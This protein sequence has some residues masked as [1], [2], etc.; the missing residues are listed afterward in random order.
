MQLITNKNDFLDVH[1][2]YVLI[3]MNIT[4]GDLNVHFKISDEL[5]KSLSDG[6]N[7]I[8]LDFNGSTF[9][10]ALAYDVMPITIDYLPYINAYPNDRIFSNISSSVKFK[11]KIKN[12]NV[13]NTYMRGINC[14]INFM[15]NEQLELITLENVSF[16]NFMNCQTQIDQYTT[17]YAPTYYKHFVLSNLPNKLVLNNCLIDMNGTMDY[18]Y[19]GGYR[20]KDPFYYFVLTCVSHKNVFVKINVLI[21]KLYSIY[22]SGKDIGIVISGLINTTISFKVTDFHYM[23]F[24]KY[25]YCKDDTPTVFYEPTTELDLTNNYKTFYTNMIKESSLYRRFIY[26]EILKLYT[27]E[28]YSLSVHNL[29]KDGNYYN[30]EISFELNN[31]T[32]NWL[33]NIT[34]N[35]INQL[36]LDLMIDLEAASELSVNIMTVYNNEKSNKLETFVNPQI[37]IDQ[38]DF[39]KNVKQIN[40]V[41]II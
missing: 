17:R 41:S 28:Q 9:T 1:D 33:Y 26:N 14:M 12:L 30:S 6:N 13:K 16:N 22:F 2:K 35:R 5:A 38:K 34:L 21:N 24:Q 20:L 25:F 40:E 10:R 18:C 19:D 3:D 32:L 39:S 8:T 7:T 11:L 37:F 27:I 15:D 4:S 23:T 36:F 31:V 29:I